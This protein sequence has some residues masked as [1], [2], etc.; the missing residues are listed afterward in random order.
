SIFDFGPMPGVHGTVCGNLDLACL[1]PLG[2]GDS[3]ASGN[4]VLDLPQAFTGYIKLESDAVEPMLFFPRLPI[5][6]GDAAQMV[7]L[8]PKGAK[9]SLATQLGDVVDNTRGLAVFL[10]YDCLQ[11][12]AAG[13]SVEL[14]GATAGSH[15]YYAFNGTPSTTAT[16]MDDTGMVGI[17]NAI[18]GTLGIRFKRGDKTIAQTSVLVREG[19]MSYRAVYV[20]DPVPA[21][22]QQ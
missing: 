8:S 1:A 16:T 17:L 20:G 22:F 21:G 5:K 4:L 2:Q 9:Q 14:L 13:V 7:F 3:D 11:V 12:A 19:Y 18:P 10:L 15:L 6:E